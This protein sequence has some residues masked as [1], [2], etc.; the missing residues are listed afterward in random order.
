MN[1]EEFWTNGKNGDPVCIQVDDRGRLVLAD[2]EKDR[3]TQ[4]QFENAIKSE[5]PDVAFRVWEQMGF[6][7]ATGRREGTL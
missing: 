1:Y 4:Y 6:W 7:M 5:F 3:I 2:V